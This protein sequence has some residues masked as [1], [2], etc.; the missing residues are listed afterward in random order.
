LAGT[1]AGIFAQLLKKDNGQTQFEKAFT[2]AKLGVFLHGAAA[3]DAAKKLGKAS[4]M[5]SDVCRQ[6]PY[7][8]KEITE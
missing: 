5:A 3:D 2:A 6:L 4:L 8:L 1:I 7:T